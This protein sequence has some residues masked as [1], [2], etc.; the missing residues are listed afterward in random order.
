[1]GAQSMPSKAAHEALTH[2]GWTCISSG[3]NAERAT[4]RHEQ[5]PGE[6]IRV[7]K[8]GVGGSSRGPGGRA[9]S[10]TAWEHFLQGSDTPVRGRG[11]RELEYHVMR[12]DIGRT[13]GGAAK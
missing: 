12:L 1:M 2:Y 5:H 7:F 3:T 4:Y 11:V 6:L 9:L 13:R 10:F 8:Q